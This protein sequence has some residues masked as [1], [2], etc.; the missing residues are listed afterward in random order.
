MES[1][2]QAFMQ[3]SK[4]STSREDTF[5][6]PPCGTFQ[7][8]KS[9]I[10]DE[11]ENRTC[12]IRYTVWAHLSSHPGI[13]HFEYLCKK[14]HIIVINISTGKPAQVFVSFDF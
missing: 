2:S 13:F 4:G 7:L 12:L 1:E 10:N 8:V 6:F 14:F 11:S 5:T 9:Q 3:L